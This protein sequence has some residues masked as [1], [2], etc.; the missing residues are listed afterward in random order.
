MGASLLAISASLKTTKPRFVSR[1]QTPWAT[2]DRA[3]ANG[4]SR[5]LL[6]GLVARPWV[7]QTFA[8]LMLFY[9]YTA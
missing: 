1:C 3:S 9:E 4:T 8:K 2:C 6:A 5:T 7:K